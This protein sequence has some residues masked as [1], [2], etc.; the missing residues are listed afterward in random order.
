MDKKL[1]C[2]VIGMADAL[3]A[4]LQSEITLVPYDVAKA[5]GLD[6]II[7]AG[8]DAA[9]S[10]AQIEK[11]FATGLS[12]AAAGAGPDILAAL[13]R[14]AGCR[15]SGTP[16]LLVYSP[17]PGTAGAFHMAST[18]V[19][20]MV[21]A[22][23]PHDEEAHMPALPALTP[24]AITAA[25]PTPAR[26]ASLFK[27]APLPA[28]VLRGDGTESFFPPGEEVAFGARE[29]IRTFSTEFDKPWCDRWIEMT[30]F[31]KKQKVDGN[32]KINFY[33]YWV[34]GG[35]DPHFIVIAKQSVYFHPA[36][37]GNEDKNMWSWHD[38]SK[39]F[40]FHTLDHRPTRLTAEGASNVSLVEWAPKL[41][42]DDQNL[43]PFS[44]EMQLRCK[45]QGG[46]RSGR[47]NF[48]AQCDVPNSF[49]TWSGKTQ[50]NAAAKETAW[51]FHS[52]NVWDSS[53][54]KPGD[55]FGRWWAEMFKYNPRHHG[56]V[57][58]DFPKQMWSPITTNTIGVWRVDC[59][60]VK[61]ERAAPKPVKV[62]ARVSGSV[63]GQLVLFHNSQ[64]CKAGHHQAWF[65]ECAVDFNQELELDVICKTSD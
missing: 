1:T 60:T 15:P 64:C 31:T 23:A 34:D 61:P 11:F 49:P 47:I 65:V 41:N 19:L 40:L 29:L 28:A 16:S 43:T 37:S 27:P 10:Q 8:A 3:T 35:G 9:V 38:S 51:K 13:D 32:L 53:T 18:G 4:A 50:V 55:D 25:A 58:E 57:R 21:M 39:G 36:L 33:C 5:E 54:E 17:V 42:F 56:Y 44:R 30:G 26:Y 14:I 45:G 59:P 6:G 48:K 24:P 20:D 22:E 7:I 52:H 63:S 46:G 12:V 62:K 2:G